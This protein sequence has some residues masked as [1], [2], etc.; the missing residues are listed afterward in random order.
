MTDKCVDCGADIKR[1][2]RRCGDCWFDRLDAIN[3]RCRREKIE[4]ANETRT[5]DGLHPENGEHDLV[6]QH[7][8]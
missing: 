8:K 1:D 5:E 2:K 7:Q 6:P 3:E 4:K